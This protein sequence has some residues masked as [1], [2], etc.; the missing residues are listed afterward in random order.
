MLIYG[1]GCVSD[2]CNRGRCVRAEQ[3][4]NAIGERLFE[5]FT[6]T[7]FRGGARYRD[8][9]GN[10]ST[11]LDVLKDDNLVSGGVS[12]NM[13]TLFTTTLETALTGTNG[14][15]VSEP[16]RRPSTQRQP[17]KAH[18]ARAGMQQRLALA[19]CSPPPIKALSISFYIK[20][21]AL[22]RCAT[23]CARRR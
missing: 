21:N 11:S 22:C 6:L 18:N 8:S 16:A 23:F 10:S 19:R 17:S 2:R 7:T 20:I 3:Y 14:F 13:T 1:S 5:P 4:G 9:V 15:R 12:A